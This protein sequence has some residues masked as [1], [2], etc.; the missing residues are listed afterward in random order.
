MA[1]SKVKEVINIDELEVIEEVITEAEENEAE[2]VNPKDV[3]KEIK[4]NA[5]EF[6]VEALTPKELDK[7]FQL[8]DQGRTIRRYLR[9]YFAENHIHKTGWKLTK[10]ETHEVIAFLATK[11]T[12]PDF[13]Q[14]NEAEKK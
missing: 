12:G 6:P 9:K 4:Q 13:T 8:G 14:L 11:F 3:I 7:I 5:P 10:T 2:A 1:K